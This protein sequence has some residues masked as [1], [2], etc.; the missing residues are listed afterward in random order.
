MR[1][2]VFFHV[3]NFLVGGIEKVLL[4]LL[5]AMDKDRYRVVLCIS[6]DLGDSETLLSQ[7]PGHVEIRRVLDKPWMNYVRRKK[8]SGHIGPL[9]KAVWESFL[10]YF[11]KKEHKAKWSRWAKEADVIVD[12][13]GTLAPYTDIIAGT[14]SAAYCHFSFG[15]IWD[16]RRYKRDR[17]AARLAK[18][19]VVVTLCDEMREEAAS[20]YPALE[21]KLA[22][23]YNALDFKQ[24][25]KLAGED[26]GEHSWLL[27]DGY[28]LSVGRLQAEQKDFATV[29]RAYAAARRGGGIKQRLVIVGQGSDR[30]RLEALAR[31]EGMG[32]CVVF[33]GFQANPYRWMAGAELFLFSSKYEGLPT[34]LIE[35]QAL[36]MPII[37]TACPTGVR[38]LLMDGQA[39]CLVPVGDVDAMRVA[40]RELVQH[41]E[42]GHQ[43][44]LAAAG[45]LQQFDMEYAMAAFER[46]VLGVE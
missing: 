18:Y 38:E 28:F 44:Q 32:D 4:E 34:V 20:L 37:A 33:T 12:F 8:T 24:I 36:G 11:I 39:G 3:N 40:I 14:R 45:L 25:R 17:L 30:E 31:E 26:L 19:D 9:G 22:R 2:A 5:R 1:K 29:I 46:V 6:Y 42:K 43:Y 7:V 41:P 13:D 23:L 27:E 35:A 16:G 15:R 10:P 21:P